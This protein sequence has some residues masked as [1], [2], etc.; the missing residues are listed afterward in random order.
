VLSEASAQSGV[1]AAQLATALGLA[2]GDLVTAQGLSEIEA[3]LKNIASGQSPA[4]LDDARVLTVAEIQQVQALEDQ[5]NQVITQ[6]NRG[7]WWHAR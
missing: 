3:A 5:H 7:C 4:P 1:P 6:Q 2:P